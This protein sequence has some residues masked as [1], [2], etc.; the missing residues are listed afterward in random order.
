VIVKRNSI[1]IVV[2]AAVLGFMVWSGVRHART[3]GPGLAGAGSSVQGNAAPD[4][5]LTD[6]KTGRTV[7][8]SDFKGKA[9]LLN[10]WATWCPPCKA[11][12]PWFVDV[13][14]QYGPQGLVVIGIAM[15]DAGRDTIARFT[16]NMKINYLVLLGDQK[17]GNAYGGVEALPTTFYIGRDGAVVK[18]VFGLTSHSD[19]EQSVKLA[20]NR[21]QQQA[22]GLQQAGRNQ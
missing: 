17:V 3:N 22:G 13:Q 18:R 9:V 19:I 15:D 8:L 5:A 7:H 20:L 21:G 1:V 10:F 16:D 14:Q 6:I 4:F 2:I 12:M 11:E